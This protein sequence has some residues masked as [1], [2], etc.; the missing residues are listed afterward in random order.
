MVLGQTVDSVKQDITVYIFLHE[1]CIISQHYT[2]ALKALYAEY[3]KEEVRFVGLFPNFSS[4]QKNIDRF[5]EKYQIPF[6][7]KTDYFRTITDKYGA[8]VTPE[9][10]VID[11]LKGQILY[12]GRIDDTYFRVGKKRRVTTTS[13]LK[14]A[15]E[16]IRNGT[17]ILV[18]ETT[19]IGCFISKKKPNQ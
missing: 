15:L 14:D 19:S 7:L 10:V 6:E 17:E 1:D 12:K 5:R 16:S 18:T 11:E 4:K 9:V 2:V 8:T 13:E 3:G